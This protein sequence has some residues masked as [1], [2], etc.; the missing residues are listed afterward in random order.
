VAIDFTP[1]EEID[2]MDLMPQGGNPWGF[3]LL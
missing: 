1:V 3:A 2:G